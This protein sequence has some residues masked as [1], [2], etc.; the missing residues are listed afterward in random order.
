MKTKAVIFDL[1]GTLYSYDD[2]NAIA[3]KKLLDSI[4]SSFGIPF[5]DASLLISNAKASVKEN[6]GNTASSHNRLLYMQKVCEFQGKSVFSYAKR[7]YDTYWDTMLE[8]MCLFSWVI[9]VFDE[10][11]RRN[12][13]IHIITDLTAAIQYR[14]IE[15]LGIEG[16]ISTFTTSEEAGEEKPSKKIFDVALSKIQAPKDSILIIGDDEKRDIM[17]A[18]NFGIRTL[19]Y[20]EGMGEEDILNTIYSENN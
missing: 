15:R 8:N 20:Q 2:C 13:S 17:G 7:F 1:D 4:S 12:I 11:T 10:L 6:L 16:Y 5:T 3:E 9:P 18:M 14:K 19:H